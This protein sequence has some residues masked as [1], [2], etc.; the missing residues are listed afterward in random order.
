M[1][2][3]LD[4]L[5]KP[6]DR[7]IMKRYKGKCKA[8]LLGGI[9]PWLGVG[10]PLQVIDQLDSIIAEKVPVKLTISHQ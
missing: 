7:N 6:A 1:Q 2:A 9:T 4:R 8:L 10:D 3:E 5:E